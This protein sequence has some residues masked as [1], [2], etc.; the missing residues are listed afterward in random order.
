MSACS[1]DALLF[2][3]YSVATAPNTA[4]IISGTLVD[5]SSPQIW[6]EVNGPANWFRFRCPPAWSVER[7]DDLIRLIPSDGS[8]S[9]TLHWFWHP[10][11]NDVSLR[12]VAHPGRLFPDSFEILRCRGLEIGEDS[13]AY[14][15]WMNCTGPM[16]WWKRP[17]VRGERRRWRL[18]ATRSECVHVMATL[19]HD[20]HC[21]PNPELDSIA[22]MVLNTLSFSASPAVPPEAFVTRALELAREKFPLLETHRSDGF[23][24]QVGDSCINLTNFYRS[25]VQQPDR[26]DEIIIP[27]LTTVVQVQE[28]GE[29]QTMPDL[30]EVRSRI[31]PML[32]PE[33]IWQSNFS[34][35][36]GTPW[37]ADLVVLYVVDE[38][39]AYWYIHEDLL[40]HWG[41]SRDE[42]HA[43]A[44]ANMADYFERKEA[45]LTYSGN[46]DSGPRL[47]M[48]NGPDAYNTVRL[49]DESFNSRLREMLG[50]EFAVGIPNRDFFVA[51]SLNCPDTLDSV[52]QRVKD[53]FDQMDHPLTNRLLLVSQ[54]GVSEYC[55]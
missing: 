51:V 50:R 32:Y 30:D 52:R 10:R 38:S 41:I 8:G 7:E 25:Y 2:A 40:E 34:G 20:S 39:S 21:R 37:V 31:M 43:L 45:D 16:P 29:N 18:W 36:L 33:E 5:H 49:L 53:D 27:A 1:D 35:F 17:F 55:P 9:L 46:H 22:T 15:G 12:D 44:L 23:A 4:L 13:I 11:P 19:L 42:L 24:I 48:P 54:D 47:L 3:I 26:F 28:W 6:Q 14:Q